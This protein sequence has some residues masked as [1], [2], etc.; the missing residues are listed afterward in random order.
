VD[1]GVFPP[2]EIAGGNGVLPFQTSKVDYGNSDLDVRNRAAILLNY[3]LPFG[4]TAHGLKG[5]LVKGW[6]TNLIG[7]YST[8]QPFSIVE[9]F[10][11]THTGIT[12][13]ERAEEIGNPY[14]KPLSSAVN[15]ASA[16]FNTAAFAAQ[17]TTGQY[18]P[19]ERNLLYGPH[20][21]TVN[22][23]VFKTFH[24][25]EGTNLEFRAESFNLTNTPSFAN[26]DGGLSD[27]TFGEITGTKGNYVPRELQFALKLLF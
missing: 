13:G 8:G 10:D 19:S 23:S 9:Y 11:N 17:P 27:S 3:S 16:V 2:A 4:Q 25:H 20:F 5:G 18:I 26:P 24:V 7:I 22:L 21:K 14:A 15:A 1:A 6:Q 12:T